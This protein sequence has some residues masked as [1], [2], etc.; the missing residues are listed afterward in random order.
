MFSLS[1]HQVPN[2]FPKFPMCFKAFFSLFSLPRTKN[3]NSP[4]FKFAQTAAATP[5]QLKVQKIKLPSVPDPTNVACLDV[6]SAAFVMSSFWGCLL[7]FF[8]LERFSNL[9]LFTSGI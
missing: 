5:Q 6:F 8:F 1:S 3:P 4:S 7:D 9:E 2:M